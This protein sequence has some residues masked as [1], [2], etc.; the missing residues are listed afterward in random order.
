MQGFLT[1][2]NGKVAFQKLEIV[3]IVISFILQ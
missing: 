1:P 2:F 3:S